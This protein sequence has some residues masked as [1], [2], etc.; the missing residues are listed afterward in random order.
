MFMSLDLHRYRLQKKKNWLITCEVKQNIH[1]AR[2]KAFVLIYDDGMEFVQV[3]VLELPR[4]II[5]KKQL[6][7]NSTKLFLMMKI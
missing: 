1:L 4:I 3:G 5:T 6:L 2:N 7:V